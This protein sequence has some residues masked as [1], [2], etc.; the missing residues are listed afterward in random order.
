MVW[1]GSILE[2]PFLRSAGQTDFKRLSIDRYK[3]VLRN[4]GYLSWCT[5]YRWAS[6]TTQRQ[7][8]ARWPWQTEV[9]VQVTQLTIEHIIH[10]VTASH[11]KQCVLVNYV[12]Y[13]HITACLLLY[14]VLTACPKPRFRSVEMSERSKFV[15]T[16]TPLISDPK[17]FSE[18]IVNPL[19]H[20]TRRFWVGLGGVIFGNFLYNSLILKSFPLDPP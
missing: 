8:T 5:V 1:F 18:I 10:H 17:E 7:T 9:K 11:A 13:G 16:E 4:C 12:L 14:T 20:T 2:T 15:L 3:V 6:M 19:N